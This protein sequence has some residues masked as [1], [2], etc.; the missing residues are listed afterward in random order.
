MYPKQISVSLVSKL[1][2]YILNLTSSAPIL[3]YICLCG[4]GSL[5]GI[6]IRIHNTGCSIHVSRLIINNHYYSFLSTHFY[7]LNNQLSFWMFRNFTAH[8]YNSRLMFRQVII[9]LES[10]NITKYQVIKNRKKIKQ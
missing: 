4:S 3:T 8:V 6:R 5:F 10:A 9:L 2:I 7:R 1:L